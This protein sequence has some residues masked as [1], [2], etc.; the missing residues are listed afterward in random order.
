MQSIVGVESVHLHQYC[1]STSHLL[2]GVTMDEVSRALVLAD[3]D[4]CGR[5]KKERAAGNLAEHPELKVVVWPRKLS[6]GVMN[7]ST[8]GASRA[9]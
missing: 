6:H 8:M 4:C 2:P 9:P 5:R 1:N 3:S 7:S